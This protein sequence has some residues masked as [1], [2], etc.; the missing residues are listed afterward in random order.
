MELQQLVW[1]FW[2]P[3]PGLGTPWP[4]AKL[5]IPWTC[6]LLAQTWVSGEDDGCRVG[7]AE[8]L[9]EKKWKRLR[10]RG[11]HRPEV[12]CLTFTLSS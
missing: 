4:G 9:E 3:H 5:S 2:S 12:S 6:C 1:S 7:F 8:Q 10:V 11:P